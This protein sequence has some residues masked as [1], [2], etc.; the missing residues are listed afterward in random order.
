MYLEIK[1]FILKVEYKI[2]FVNKLFR[3]I[4]IVT[5]NLYRFLAFLMKIIQFKF[6]NRKIESQNFAT[7]VEN[8]IKKI[9]I[10]V[11]PHFLELIWNY[12]TR[13]L[14]I[15]HSLR[16]SCYGIYHYW[17]YSSSINIRFNIIKKLKTI[18]IIK[19]NINTFN[20]CATILLFIIKSNIATA[21]D[22]KE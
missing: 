15:F 6:Q 1:S 13:F 8:R 3:K 16:E 19:Y 14:A 5:K 22:T 17:L 10:V 9:S 7:L 12:K 11:I 18:F 21:T 2:R 4:R 20:T